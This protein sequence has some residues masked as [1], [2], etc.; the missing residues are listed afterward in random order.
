MSKEEEEEE[1]TWAKKQRYSQ[2]L[3]NKTNTLTKYVDKIIVQL[4][5]KSL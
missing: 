2:P 5:T 1:T 3:K 4:N